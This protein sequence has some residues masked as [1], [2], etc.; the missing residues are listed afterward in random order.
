MKKRILGNDLEVSALGLGCMGF[1]HAYGKP[2]EDQEVIERIRKAYDLGYTFFDTAEV[3]GT[4]EDPHI[5]EELVGKAL[6]P[7]RDQVV[8]STKFGLRFDVDSNIY[9]YPLIPDATKK[10]I[11][12]SVEGS[13]MRL[14][15]D[16]IDLYF[17]HRI[18][19][20]VVP[21]E[22][23]SV[24][25]DLIKEGKITHW[26]VSEANEDYLRRAHK[27]CPVTAV[28]NRYSMMARHHESLF[29][30]CEELN[31]GFVAFS[32]MA[33]GLLT[34][35]YHQ[36][37]HFDKEYDYRA[38]MPQ[39]TQSAMKEN[40]ELFELLRNL[41]SQKHATP[42]QIS[43]AWMLCKKPWIVPI[44]G[45]R[46]IKRMQENALS[47]EILLTKEEIEKLDHALDTIKMS[48]VFGGSKIVNKE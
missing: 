9:P 29:K 27:V 33:N 39:F 37:L 41:S 38:T 35:K 25:S 14:D 31:I 30:T 43:L 32:P 19:L 40:E 20:N 42:A 6:K 26:G 10:A 24:M 28:Q 15:T 11:R 13:L 47:S 7:V 16:H 36:N 22:V 2:T 23:A 44:P 8:I 4:S 45:T 34:D 17:Q 12:K 3:Y 5:N 1:S 46:S 48:D 18:D 21:E